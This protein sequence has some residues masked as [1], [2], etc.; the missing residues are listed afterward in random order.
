MQVLSDEVAELKQLAR[1]WEQQAQEN[2]GTIERLKD[3]LEDSAAWDDHQGQPAQQSDAVVD[4]T[5]EGVSGEA[6]AEGAAAAAGRTP[7]PRRT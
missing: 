7:V 1:T 6:A 5:S 4:L 3:L 2:L